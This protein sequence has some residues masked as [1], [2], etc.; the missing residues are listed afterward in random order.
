VNAWRVTVDQVAGSGGRQ[1]YDVAAEAPTL[2]EAVNEALRRA[3]LDAAEVG[4][5]QITVTPVVA[6][7]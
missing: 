4:S 5:Y 2:A 1:R 7:C 3:E 6:P